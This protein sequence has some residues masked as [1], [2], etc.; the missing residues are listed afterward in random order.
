VSVCDDT[1]RLGHLFLVRVIRPPGTDDLVKPGIKWPEW[2]MTL[3][4]AG[5][6]DA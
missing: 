1:V 4:K 5:V 2:R 6:E 3:D